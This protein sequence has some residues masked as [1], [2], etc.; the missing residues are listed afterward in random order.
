MDD[1]DVCGILTMEFEYLRFN[2]RNLQNEVDDLVTEIVCVCP[3]TP[4]DHVKQFASKLH[5][6]CDILK[7]MAERLRKMHH[8]DPEA[9][10]LPESNPPRCECEDAEDEIDANFS[11]VGV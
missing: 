6:L 5:K 2:L 1:E 10:R 8:Y 11:S 9:C 3:T 7:Y 4:Y